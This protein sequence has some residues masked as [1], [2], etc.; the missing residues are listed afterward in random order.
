LIVFGQVVVMFLF[1]QISEGADAIVKV[2]REFGVIEMMLI[3]LL[4]FIGWMLWQFLKTWKANDTE[5]TEAYVKS[6]HDIAVEMKES[7]R[8]HTA[9]AITTSEAVA[10]MAESSVNTNHAV[11][12]IGRAIESQVGYSAAGNELMSRTYNKTE[13]IH[14]A[15]GGMIEV[16]MEMANGD[17]SL[18]RQ[19]KNVQ[20][21]LHE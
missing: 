20:E 15:I 21:E 10:K 9:S 18:L 4:V 8:A 5:R 6:Q 2:G 13:A 11:E 3:G 1:G 19:L 14:R 7:Y 17:A 16:A 12:S